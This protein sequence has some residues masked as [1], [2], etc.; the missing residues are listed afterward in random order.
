MGSCLGG[1]AERSD[2]KRSANKGSVD[3]EEDEGLGE[4]A[5]HGKVNSDVIQPINSELN[6]PFQSRGRS[7]EDL[8]M[9]D[10]REFSRGYGALFSPTEHPAIYCRI[11]Q[12]KS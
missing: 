4:N 10:I 11:L 1:L 3:R 5:L 2:C 7:H 6:C 12:R 8:N 9:R